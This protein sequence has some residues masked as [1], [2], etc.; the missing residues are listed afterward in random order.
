MFFLEVD[1]NEVRHAVKVLVVDFGGVG[2]GGV[3]DGVSGVRLV[4]GIFGN[5]IRFDDLDFAGLRDEVSG[6]GVA[7]GGAPGVRNAQVVVDA[8][9]AVRTGGNFRI[10]RVVLDRVGAFRTSSGKL[11]TS[12]WIWR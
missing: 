1:S 4:E 7:D 10:P 3:L 2:D 5:G 8:F 11:G 6:I 9:V 12:F